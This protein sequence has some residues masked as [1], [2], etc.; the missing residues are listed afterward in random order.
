M[1][2]HARALLETM[3][4]RVVKS[5]LLLTHFFTSAA[6]T[7]ILTSR[8]MKNASIWICSC[9]I[10]MWRCSEKQVIRR[11]GF[12][13]LIQTVSLDVKR[14]T[15]SSKRFT[16]IRPCLDFLISS[17]ILLVLVFSSLCRVGLI[18]FIAGKYLT[19]NF[20]FWFIT[21]HNMQVI[22]QGILFM[23]KVAAK[24]ENIRKGN[25]ETD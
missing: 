11:R 9:S 10:V 19:F 21:N 7:R 12:A 17:F 20:L 4:Y 15:G 14:H 2:S 18:L 6:D 22:F 23:I 25:S 3:C 8:K 5:I 16:F 13:S 1:Y 24:P